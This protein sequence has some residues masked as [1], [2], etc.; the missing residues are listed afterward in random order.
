M[1]GFRSSD[2]VLDADWCCNDSLTAPLFA[3][4][5]QLHSFKQ[6]LLS[7]LEQCPNSMDCTINTAAPS[8]DS[9]HCCWLTTSQ[10]WMLIVIWHTHWSFPLS[11]GLLL[12]LLACSN[13]HS[14]SAIV[15]QMDFN[16]QSWVHSFCSM[17]VH[18]NT[19]HSFGTPSPLESHSF[20]FSRFVA[21]HAVWHTDPDTWV[22]H[23]ETH[24]F[25][26]RCKETCNALIYPILPIIGYA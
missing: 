19:F 18:G 1:F 23:L 26:S 12:W 10:W 14:M 21:T 4:L 8:R 7:H 25:F 13:H 22:T 15:S 9:C 3:R 6:M 17:L 2:S 5:H 24:S 11:F 16:M 20:S